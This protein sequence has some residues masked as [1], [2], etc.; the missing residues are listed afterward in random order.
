MFPLTPDQHHW[1]DVATEDEGWC[2]FRSCT[3][4]IQSQGNTFSQHM[5]DRCIQSQGNTF[6]EHMYDRCI[7]SQGNTFS[8]HMYAVF[9]NL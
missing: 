5:Y 7:Q 1:L 6:S 9:R 2:S 3:P 4:S 8:E